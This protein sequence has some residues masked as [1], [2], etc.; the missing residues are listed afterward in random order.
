MENF[1][2][3][4]QLSDNA[5]K[6]YVKCMGESPRTYGELC[7]L[8]PDL[9]PEQ[10]EKTIGELISFGLLRQIE[11]ETHDVLTYYQTQP[12][13]SQILH[14]YENISTNLN[15]MKVAIQHLIKNTINIVIKEKNEIQL[16]TVFN[17]LKEVIDDI[18]EDTLLQKQE[19]EDIVLGI[20]G[21]NIIKELFLDFKKITNATIQNELTRLIKTLPTFKVNI[22]EKLHLLELKKKEELVINLLEEE[23]NS[24]SENLTEDFTSTFFNIIEDNFKSTQGAIEKSIN[25]MFQYRNEFKM[26][27]LGMISNFE[28]NMNKIFEMIG[29]NRDNLES[30]LSILEN[31]IITKINSIILKS[32]DQV[33]ELN[34]PIIEVLHQYL[35]H[36]INQKQLGIG[37][38]WEIN[39][40]V[41]INEEIINIINNSEENFTL[42]I[43][44]IE[45]FLSIEEIQNLPSHLK[46]NIA[47]SDPSTNSRVKKIQELKNLQFKQ[48]QNKNIVICRSDDNL[49]V[50]GIIL[51]GS[52]DPLNDFIGLGCNYPPLI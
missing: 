14:H 9:S 16:D 22:I 21:I 44:K 41:K 7:I 33:S 6:L 43:P 31:N 18:N 36:I 15:K 17:E 38:V 51:E 49:I 24:Y 39:S 4:L 29:E 48:L 19:I 20:E 42:I 32:I 50:L 35:E 28:Q 45:D 2:K 10:C 12:P 27:L 11:S 13:I 34:N 8:L 23:F 25:T 47:S 40:K 5:I 37:N 46:I 52:S 3:Q 30:G 26:L 1:F